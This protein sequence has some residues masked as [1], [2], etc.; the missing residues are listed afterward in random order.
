MRNGARAVWFT[1]PGAVEIGPAPL[2]APGPGNVLVR[3]T[4]SGVSPGTEMLAYRG[5]LDEEQPRDE[6][7]TSLDG[8]FRYP[9][10]YGYSAVGVVEESKSHV[11]VGTQ[12]FA[13]HPHQDWFTVAEDDVVV[14]DG[15][16]PRLGTLFPLV[17]TALQMTLDS[18]LQ[19]GDRA[20]VMGL[21]P[22]GA[23]CSLILARSGIEVIGVD[24]LDWRRATL[25]EL[26]DPGVVTVHP[27]SVVSAVA[28]TGDGS[29]PVVIEVSGDPRALR[30]GLQLLE[31]EG[32]LLVG[33]WFG[34]REVPLPLGDEFH[35]RRLTI[36]STQVSTIPRSLSHRW[37]K[38]KRRQAVVDLMGELPLESLATHTFPFE[39]APD[40]FEAI[41]RRD[42][43]L[44]HT[45]LAYD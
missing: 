44:I 29:V 14:I 41:D 34:K 33:S 2:D 13:F 7:I 1:S 45:A 15:F 21:G 4:H 17:E 3:T 36:R 27:D 37:D 39:D 42:D 5:D 16:A 20:V 6:T 30:Q 26:E 25:A 10:R 23:L 40:A 38:E 22:V 18:G 24:P 43:G 11:P 8:T 19:P 35:R 31:H 12:V 28:E 9:F 32:T